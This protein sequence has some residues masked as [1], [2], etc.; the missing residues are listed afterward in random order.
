VGEWVSGLTTLP[1][2]YITRKTKGAKH[3]EKAEYLSQS[4]TSG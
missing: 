1:K 2:I 3:L 4:P